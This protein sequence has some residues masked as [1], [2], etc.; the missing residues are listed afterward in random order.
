MGAKKCSPWEYV[1]AL[2]G[3]LARPGHQKNANVKPKDEWTIKYDYVNTQ[4]TKLDMN[5]IK[6]LRD[7]GVGD[8]VIQIHQPTA[9]FYK[10]EVGRQLPQMTSFKP[11]C[12]R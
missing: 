12:R 10:E 2:S 11:N 8:V 5:Y 4:H 6:I 9:C 3:W 1:H 7:F